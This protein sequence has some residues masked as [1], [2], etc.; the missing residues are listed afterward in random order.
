RGGAG[1]GGRCAGAGAPLGARRPGR[2][3]APGAPGQLAAGRHPGPDPAAGHHG[4]RHRVRADAGHG[5]GPPARPGD[6]NR[7]GQPERR[8]PRG[9][10]GG[11]PDRPPPGG[12]PG[13][14]GPGPAPRRGTAAG[15][16]CRQPNGGSVVNGQVMKS[17]PAGF[18]AELAVLSDGTMTI[19]QQDFTGTIADGTA[20]EPL[21]SI[22]ILADAAAGRVTEVTPALAAAAQKLSKA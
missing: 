1:A 17:P 5:P 11:H 9:R 18:N 12:P 10:G 13:P 4:R 2:E 16:A 19:G 22:N 21:T 20:T 3:L 15:R 6:A 14:G 7:P 8:R